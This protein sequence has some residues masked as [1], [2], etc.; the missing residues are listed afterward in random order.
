MGK[1]N[2]PGRKKCPNNIKRDKKR[3]NLRAYMKIMDY[4]NRSTV[5]V[6]GRGKDALY[7]G[8]AEGMSKR[9]LRL[10]GDYV[11]LTPR[12]KLWGIRNLE[13]GS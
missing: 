3:V 8:Q 1:K 13:V 9:R 11:G 12:V 5:G 2:V 10:A 6:G 7:L 4:R